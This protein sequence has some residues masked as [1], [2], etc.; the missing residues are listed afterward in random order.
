MSDLEEKTL[1]LEA[2]KNDFMKMLEE[3]SKLDAKLKGKASNVELVLEDILKDSE[4][5][6]IVSLERND[7]LERNLMKLKEE[8]NKSLK[9]TTFSKLLFDMTSQRSNG[10]MSL[11]YV[12]KIDPSFN[13][14]S[15]YFS[16]SDD[17]ICL[18]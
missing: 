5:K 15:K 3:G 12:N 17:L 14:N 18:H 6:L 16:M 10:G 2:E 9:W 1:A 8:L 13:P 4:V 11:G 7:Q